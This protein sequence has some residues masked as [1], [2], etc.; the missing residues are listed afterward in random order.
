[1][2]ILTDRFIS[3][4][5]LREIAYNT[6]PKNILSFCK[7]NKAMVGICRSKNFWSKYIN[8]RQSRYKA[9]LFVAARRGYVK[10]WQQL[11][12]DKVPEGVVAEPILLKKMFIVSVIRGNEELSDIIWSEYSKWNKKSKFNPNHLEEEKFIVLLGASIESQ[13]LDF[14]LTLLKDWYDD[15]AT[16]PMLNKAFACSPSY[17]FLKQL[18][19][20]A[21][22]DSDFKNTLQLNIDHIFTNA[23]LEGNMPIVYGLLDKITITGAD[24]VRLLLNSRSSRVLEVLHDK[25]PNYEEIINCRADI[26]FFVSLKN[27]RV[28]LDLY[29]RVKPKDRRRVLLFSPWF[30]GPYK[31]IQML[32]NAKI[33][34]KTSELEYLLYLLKIRGEYY[35]QKIISEEAPL[36]K[37]PNKNDK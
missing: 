24:F 25:Y 22:V 18:L 10:L 3:E 31:F 32:K 17:K 9:L 7:I 34:Y 33:C 6:S 26:G 11:W 23:V 36:C 20:Y 21:K 28:F 5:E 30:L 1:M 14:S 29:R 19:K 4:D 35:K 37:P 12:L 27:P 16:W 8:G 2:E 15:Y 13:D